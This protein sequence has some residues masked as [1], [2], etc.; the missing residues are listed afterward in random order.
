MPPIALE[1]RRAGLFP[2][3]RSCIEIYDKRIEKLMAHVCAI[4]ARLPEVVL[5]SNSSLLSFAFDLIRLDLDDVSSFIYSYNR[6]KE[7]T[8]KEQL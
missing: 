5:F 2:S 8:K 3:G 7:K 6:N 4:T 1:A